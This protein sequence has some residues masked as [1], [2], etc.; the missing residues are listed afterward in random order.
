[1]LKCGSV[2]SRGYSNFLHFKIAA[3]KTDITAKPLVFSFA[4]DALLPT[5]HVSHPREHDDSVGMCPTTFALLSFS[6]SD[7][8]R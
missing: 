3:N 4:V 1:M 5:G 6:F 8:G 7:G 2:T